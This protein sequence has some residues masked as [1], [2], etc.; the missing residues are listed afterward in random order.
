MVTY[1]DDS[2]E[3]ENDE[4]EDGGGP[5][6]EDEDPLEETGTDV[7]RTNPESLTM[8][9]RIQSICVENIV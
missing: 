3:D 8:F 5:P 4:E 6:K 2:A 1:S 9:K 7:W